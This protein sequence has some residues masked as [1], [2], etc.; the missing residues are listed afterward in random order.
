MNYYEYDDERIDVLDNVLS[1]IST[2]KYDD[3]LECINNLDSLE[4]NDPLLLMSKA[5]CYLRLDKKETAY[6]IYGQAIK[7]CDE[8]LKDKKDPFILNI[9]GNCYLKEIY[10]LPYLMQQLSQYGNSLFANG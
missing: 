2:R 6:E 4:I 7:L 3:A 8:N 5:Q 9:K 1:C 10:G